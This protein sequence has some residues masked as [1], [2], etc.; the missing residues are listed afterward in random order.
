MLS[1]FVA[2]ALR[3]QG[4]FSTLVVEKVDG[5]SVDFV[6]SEHPSVSMT[7]DK[8]SVS[9]NGSNGVEYEVEEVKKFYFKLY[10]PAESVE[11]KLVEGK[12]ESLRVKSV[13]GQTVTITGT[14]VTDHLMLYT[15]DGRQVQR[16][17]SASEGETCI[18]I[19]SL[20][21]G[22]YLIKVNDKQTFKILKR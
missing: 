14:S 11:E 18:R 1:V 2:V 5:S 20:E 13:D 9:T 15:S 17:I 16:G 10:D 4:E 6:L 8:V 7:G 12:K 21:K 3:A 19:G 22:L